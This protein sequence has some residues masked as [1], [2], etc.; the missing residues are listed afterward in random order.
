[1]RQHL[2]FTVCTVSQFPCSNMSVTGDRQVLVH[3]WA[4]F[5]ELQ[6]R[7][8][9]GF[10][11]LF[12]RVVLWFFDFKPSVHW[13]KQNPFRNLSAYPSTDSPPY[14]I[15][16]PPSQHFC[17]FDRVQSPRN[18]NLVLPPLQTILLNEPRQFYLFNAFQTWRQLKDFHRD[19]DTRQYVLGQSWATTDRHVAGGLELTFVWCFLVG[20]CCFEGFNS[21]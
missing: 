9:L 15:L 6:T 13:D 14:S 3:I 1:M 11:R 7:N 18:Q 19:A 4:L 2:F 20:L 10:Q 12:N 16:I 21:F 17:T 5:S 8:W